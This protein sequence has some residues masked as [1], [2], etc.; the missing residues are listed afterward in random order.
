MIELRSRQGCTLGHQAAAFLSQPP[1]RPGAAQCDCCRVW[2][3]LHSSALPADSEKILRTPLSGQ[4]SLPDVD[5]H[6]LQPVTEPAGDAGPGAAR[7]EQEWAQLAD[8][9]REWVTSPASLSQ[10]GFRQAGSLRAS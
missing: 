9:L 3:A 7:A 1:R 10:P 6:A 2:L 5:L 4:S 8:I